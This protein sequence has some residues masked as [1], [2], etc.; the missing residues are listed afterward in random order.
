MIHLQNLVIPPALIEQN[1]VIPSDLQYID[2]CA[3]VKMADDE[4]DKVVNERVTGRKTSLWKKT[5]NKS[6]FHLLPN[7]L[8][9]IPVALRA[10]ALNIWFH[11]LKSLAGSKARDVRESIENELVAYGNGGQHTAPSAAEN[12]STQTTAD[13]ENVN[14]TNVVSSLLSEWLVA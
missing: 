7:D 2:S 6:M 8:S 11:K 4:H 13:D 1:P 9:A 5:R 12:E 10:S 3:H 14:T